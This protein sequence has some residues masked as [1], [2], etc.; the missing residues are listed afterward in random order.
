MYI[1]QS[2][3]QQGSLFSKAGDEGVH[4]VPEVLEKIPGSLLAGKSIPV[5][6]NNLTLVFKQ[7]CWQ[8]DGQFGSSFEYDR[9]L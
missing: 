2:R 5:S 1:H 8:Y 4:I 3:G 9:I 6:R 7:F